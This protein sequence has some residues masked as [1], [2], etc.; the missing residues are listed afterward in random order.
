MG[1][2]PLADIMIRFTVAPCSRGHGSVGANGWA[3]EVWWY[4][5]PTTNPRRD[6]AAVHSPTDYL[7]LSDPIMWCPGTGRA[8]RSGPAGRSYRSAPAVPEL[9][10]S[11]RLQ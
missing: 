8:I 9:A 5:H 11:N 10:T 6:A 3:N 2:F 1:V 4:P 7:T